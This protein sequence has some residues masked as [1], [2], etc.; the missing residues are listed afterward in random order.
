MIRK[1]AVVV[2]VVGATLAGRAPA[3][4]DDP[5]VPAPNSL[6]RLRGFSRPA[7]RPVGALSYA[8]GTVTAAD[9]RSVTVRSWF[10]TGID[11]AMEEDRSGT[12]R[13]GR[14][15][16]QDPTKPIVL[17]YPG[18]EVDCHAYRLTPEGMV[19]TLLSGQ[20]VVLRNTDRP[21]RRFPAVPELIRGEPHPA[22]PTRKHHCH[23]LH[24]VRVGDEVGLNLTGAFGK[25]E[26]VGVTISRRPGGRVP[27][28]TVA[29]ERFRSMIDHDNVYQDHEEK[30]TPIPE[31]FRRDLWLLRREGLFRDEAPPPPK[32]P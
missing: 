16:R 26:C 13:F 24:E 21:T 25:E 2:L 5:P 10:G 3:P 8:A 9:A 1:F 22:L 18:W 6:D 12:D 7:I 15:V 19:V 11:N 4:A 29:T 31:M 28:S 30:G 14:W 27:H 20:E 23:L 17:L 32:R